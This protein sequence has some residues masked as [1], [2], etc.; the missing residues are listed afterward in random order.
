[1]ETRTLVAAGNHPESPAQFHLR[2]HTDG[3]RWRRR[4]AAEQASGWHV[5]KLLM[6]GGAY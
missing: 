2:A 3:A 4:A 5:M 6:P 1:M